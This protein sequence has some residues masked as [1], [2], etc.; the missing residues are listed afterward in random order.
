V[1]KTRHFPQYTRILQH[2]LTYI[3]SYK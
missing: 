1:Y 3:L 2:K